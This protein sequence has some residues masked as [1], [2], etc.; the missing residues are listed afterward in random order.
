MNSENSIMSN[1]RIPG[2]THNKKHIKKD[3][4]DIDGELMSKPSN[5]LGGK[6]TIHNIMFA[7]EVDG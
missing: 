7:G 6:D 2:Q 1:L 5:R 3:E 4:N